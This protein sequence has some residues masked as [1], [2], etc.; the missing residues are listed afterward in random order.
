MVELGLGPRAKG[1]GVSGP[2]SGGI[3]RFFL[4]NLSS[5]GPENRL[6]FN[7]VMVRLGAQ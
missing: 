1:A 6:D 2:S 4:V 3:S 7:S 5:E